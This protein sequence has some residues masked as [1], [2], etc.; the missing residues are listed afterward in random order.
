MF[1]EIITQYN[2]DTNDFK[3]FEFE[4]IRYFSMSSPLDKS[5]FENASGMETFNPINMTKV[6]ST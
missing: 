6:S 5:K 2:K 4:L 3:N 1:L